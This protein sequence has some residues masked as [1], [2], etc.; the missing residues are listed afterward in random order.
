MKNALS[1]P[2]EAFSRTLTFTQ[3]EDS[4]E[5]GEMKSELELT[6]DKL[7][8]PRMSVGL[9]MLYRLLDPL[10]GTPTKPSEVRE[11][12]DNS[13]KERTVS[14]QSITNAAIRLEEAKM[15]ERKEGY[16]VNYGYLI[17]VLL[18]SVIDLKE[19]I[20]DLEDE[21]EEIKET[22]HSTS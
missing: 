5:R 16:Q 19:R 4:L 13:L 2:S 3:Y 7:M 9:M 20:R 14:K 11:S 10:K 21:I 17:S 18:N 6:L 12:V 1:D 22:V 15:L 8:N